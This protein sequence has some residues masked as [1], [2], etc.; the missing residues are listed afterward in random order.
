MLVETMIKTVGEINGRKT[1]YQPGTDI[2]RKT[3]I[4]QSCR[5][6]TGITKILII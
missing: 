4:S 1:K 5:Y 2:L 6:E 3:Q